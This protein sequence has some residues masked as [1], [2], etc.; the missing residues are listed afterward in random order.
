MRSS[1]RSWRPAVDEPS[2][3]RE[4]LPETLRGVLSSASS[5]ASPRRAG[6][7]EIAAV[8]GAQVDHDVLA[9]VCG[10]YETALAAALREAVDAQ[11]LL[12][13][14]G[15]VRRPLPLPPRAGPGGRVRPAAAVGTPPPPRG[16]R[17]GARGQRPAPA[18]AA[19]ASRLVEIAHHWRVGPSTRP[20][21][22]TA[23]IAGRRRLAGRLRLRRGGPPVRAGDRAWDLVPPDDRPDDRDLGDL[24][25][26]A[27][28]TS[29]PSSAM[30]PRAV[31]PRPARDR[32]G[33]R[34]ADGADRDRE[35]RAR[36]RER[37]GHR[38]LAGRRH[39]DVD[40]AA[41]GGGR[42]LEELQPWSGDSSPSTAHRA[43]ARVLAG[44]AANLMLA[45]RSS[46]SSPGRRTR[47]RARPNRRRPRDR[48]ARDWA[49]SASTARPR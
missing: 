34:R 10:L 42:P 5:A 22:C 33:R 6:L 21:R 25:D 37:L 15:R 12:V 28:A 39:R 2:R 11:L 45:G 18:V 8:A 7:V 27:S 9:D 44:L 36:A 35:R 47:D 24:Y 46:D 19:E 30:D 32:A 16:L 40:P 31:E 26:A 38:R 20:A 43:R 17:G 4:R 29:R 14:P 1:P 23:A 41:R 49:S 48:I 3:G 13:V